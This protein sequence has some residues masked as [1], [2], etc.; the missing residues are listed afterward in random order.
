M[1]IL[2]VWL[3]IIFSACASIAEKHSFLQEVL[4][5]EATADEKAQMILDAM[6]Y[7]EKIRFLSGEGWKDHGT[8]KRLGLPTISYEDATAGIFLNGTNYPAPLVAAASWNSELLF[9]MGEAVAKEGRYYGKDIILGPGV[10]I[11]R[12]PTCGRNFEYFGEDPYLASQLAISY[13]NG[14]QSDGSIA[15]IKHYAGNNQD[16]DRHT[17]SSDIDERTLREIY[18]PTFEAAVKAGVGIVM[19]GYNPLNGFPMSEN[20]RMITDILKN[21]WGF[22]GFVVSDFY[23]VYSTEG[24]FV[25]GLDLEMPQKSGDF[26]VKKIKNLTVP[27]KDK[28]LNEKVFRILKTYLKFGVYDR[29]VAGEKEIPDFEKWNQLAQK[30]AEEGIILLKNEDNLLP[31]KKDKEQTILLV[32]RSSRRFNTTAIGACTVFNGRLGRLFTVGLI[33]GFKEYRSKNTKIRWAS[34]NDVAALKKADAVIYTIGLGPFGEGEV[35]DRSWDMTRR[36]LREIE[37]LKKYNKNIIVISNYGAGIETESW[38]DGVKCFIH[39]GIAGKW[40]D[41]ALARII[42]GDVNPSGKLTYTMVKEWEDFAP[43]AAQMQHPELFVVHPRDTKYLNFPLVGFGP[44]RAYG[45]IS[46]ML[47]SKN[48]DQFE[49]STESYDKMKHMTYAEGR[50]LGYRYLDKV[51]KKAQFP[52]GFGLSY[53]TF[54]FNHLTVS[55]KSI[56]AAES[57]NIKVTVTNTG[58]MSGAEVVQL[59][60]SAKQPQ[61][62]RVLK[63]L[64]GFE[65]VFLLPGESQTVSID[66]PPEAFRYYDVDEKRWRI[67]PGEYEILI[68]NS[69]ANL[70]LKTA[71]TVL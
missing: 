9:A 61:T 49:Y 15:V 53:T 25:S 11:Y 6:T 59:Y 16:Y 8:V 42:F 63:E 28:L 60:V 70:I 51:G 31:L 23:S 30:I 22:D 56:S 5:L 14:V 54:D 10:N 7:E 32:G 46:K 19:S 12:M 3:C 13:I 58:E 66:L 26:A 36:N 21:E 62:D 65:K 27:D 24:A 34:V 68:G 44:R 55:Q 45:G 35:N 2:A 52:F 47:K 40:A 33:D 17:V 69:S 71:V 50:Y 18:L 39:A 37:K 67:D 41:R 57:T 4:S 20:K 64:K 29:I 1:R 38:I 48:P 43:V